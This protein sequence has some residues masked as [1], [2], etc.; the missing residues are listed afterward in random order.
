MGGHALFMSESMLAKAADVGGP[1]CRAEMARV[2]ERIHVDLW[3]NV[4]LATSS[5]GPN[6][7]QVTAIAG[8]K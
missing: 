3:R 2:A 8:A 6:A 4:R 5:V 1:V 7:R